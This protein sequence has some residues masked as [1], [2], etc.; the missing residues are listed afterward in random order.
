MVN[1]LL[2]VA[3]KNSGLDVLVLRLFPKHKVVFLEACGI[4]VKT[5][6]F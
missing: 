2:I 4:L 5:R 1:L 3:V 6:T